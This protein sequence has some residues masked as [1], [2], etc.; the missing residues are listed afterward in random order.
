MSERA[1]QRASSSTPRA[2]AAYA[3]I[4]RQRTASFAWFVLGIV[5]W[6]AWTIWQ[7]RSLEREVDSRSLDYALLAAVTFGMSVVMTWGLLKLRRDLRGSR[8]LT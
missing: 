6:I 3:R 5:G 1:I 2:R 4:H 7:W 8:E